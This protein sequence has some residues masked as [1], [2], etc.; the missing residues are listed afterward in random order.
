MEDLEIGRKSD[1]P[2]FPDF[3]GRGEGRAGLAEFTGLCRI[4]IC[5]RSD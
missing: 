3:P 5:G 4:S 1:F 2:D